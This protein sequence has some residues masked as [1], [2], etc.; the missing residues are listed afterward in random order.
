M[1]FEEDKKKIIL[2]IKKH[3]P[4]AKIYLFGSRAR[5]KNSPGSDIDIA[6]DAGEKIDRFFIGNINEDLEESNIPFCVDIIDF[7]DVSDGMKKQ[8]IKERILW[9]S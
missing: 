3:I 5:G 7:Y 8:I 1:N 6:L 2:I 4:D 9:S